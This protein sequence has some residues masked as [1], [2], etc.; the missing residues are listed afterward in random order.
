M[1]TMTLTTVALRERIMDSMLELAHCCKF[2]RILVAGSSAPDLMLSLH[3]RGYGRVS[4][5][6]T[7]GLPHGQYSVALI[8]WRGRSIKAL[9]S[10]LNWLVQYL[11]PCAVL[12]V[13]L[14]SRDGSA[15]RQIRMHP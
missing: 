14:D 1:V 2:H 12:V 8:D 7:C 5:L 3:C 11:A 10:T 6:A 4:T 9:E 15:D 13:W